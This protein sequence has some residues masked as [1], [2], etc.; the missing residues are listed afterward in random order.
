MFSKK[1]EKKDSRIQGFEDSS[2]SLGVFLQN[3]KRQGVRK[4]RVRYASMHP[5]I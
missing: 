3:Q 5:N 2:G 1:P 4:D